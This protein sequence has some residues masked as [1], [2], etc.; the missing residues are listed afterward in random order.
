MARILLICGATEEIVHMGAVRGQVEGTSNLLYQMRA[1]LRL[2]YETEVSPL[3]LT[4]SFL[5]E[6]EA[7][8]S[9]YWRVGICGLISCCPCVAV[10][11]AR[12]VHMLI[13]PIPRT[14]IYNGICKCS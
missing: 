10:E 8:I 11:A 13:H 9:T 2:C 6:D 3:I 1:R 5:Y 7:Q 4:I 12:G 14:T